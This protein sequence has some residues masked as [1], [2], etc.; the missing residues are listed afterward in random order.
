MSLTYC[1]TNNHHYY[2][3]QLVS[4]IYMCDIHKLDTNCYD[5]IKFRMSQSYFLWWLECLIYNR[6]LSLQ[7]NHSMFHLLQ[8]ATHEG[9]GQMYSFYLHHP[10]KR[11]SDM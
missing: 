8:Y 5:N 4:L 2:P 9:M 11:C 6:E 3:L 10:T 1:L 7:K